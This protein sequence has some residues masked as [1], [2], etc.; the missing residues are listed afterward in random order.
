MPL[1]RFLWLPIL[2]GIV[3]RTRPAQSAEK[4]AQVWMPEGSP[5]AVHTVRQAQL[6]AERLGVP[7]RYAMR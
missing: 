7:V 3:L 2:H 5:L 6:L 1:P 4:Y